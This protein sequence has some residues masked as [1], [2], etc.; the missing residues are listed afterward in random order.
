MMAAGRCDE[1]QQPDL[2]D[3][4]VDGGWQCVVSAE[5]IPP[6]SAEFGARARDRRSGCPGKI[7]MPDRSRPGI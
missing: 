5:Y 3:T 1:R 2:P 4:I 6:F 7:S